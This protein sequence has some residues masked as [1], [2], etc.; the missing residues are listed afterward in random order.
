M[1]YPELQVQYQLHVNNAHLKP[2]ICS[3]PVLLLLCFLFPGTEW[4]W[5]KWLPLYLL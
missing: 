1:E 3:S 4:P 5:S 2:F